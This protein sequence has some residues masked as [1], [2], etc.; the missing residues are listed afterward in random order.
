MANKEL[1]QAAEMFSKSTQTLLKTLNVMTDN[2]VKQTT[3]N[4]DLENAKKFSNFVNSGGL[5]ELI[6]EAVNKAKSQT[7]K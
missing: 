6:T 7:E 1:K 2:V 5:D 4:L 3:E